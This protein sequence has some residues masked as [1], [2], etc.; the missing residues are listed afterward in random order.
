[1]H[2]YKAEQRVFLHGLYSPGQIA[3]IFDEHFDCL[4]VIMPKKTAK[5]P[6]STIQKNVESLTWV[7]KRKRK[8]TLLE[9]QVYSNHFSILD[10]LEEMSP[11]ETDVIKMLLR[12]QL[13][14]LP[15]HPKRKIPQMF[16]PNR[17]EEFYVTP[18]V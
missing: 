8:N 14:S 1:M 9:V 17:V 5:P 6:R 2:Q 12:A 4:C 11:L 13:A 7:Y 16:H 15:I 18:T 3:D 10:A